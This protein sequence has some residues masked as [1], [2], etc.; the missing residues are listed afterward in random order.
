M[1][2][3]RSWVNV[4]IPH[5]RGGE[6]EA[7]PMRAIGEL[8]SRRA[9][10]GCPSRHHALQSGRAEARDPKGVRTQWIA[11]DVGTSR[12]FPGGPP[13]EL[14][15]S[16]PGSAR[17]LGARLDLELDALTP[18]EAVE[19]QGGVEGAAME[20]VFLRILGDDE[21]E[22]AIG[23]DLLD[24]TGGH[25]TSKRFPNRDGST[26]GPFEKGEIDHAEHRH[27]SAASTN[28]STARSAAD[29]PMTA[30]RIGRRTVLDADGP[31]SALRER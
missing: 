6:V 8:L 18:G 14:S 28:H 30:S 10:V 3:E 4:A 12:P 13:S 23:D 1:A 27:C 11:R 25:G 16:D 29:H 31:F 9:H 5:C 22:A 17:T 15:G 24:G 19:V 21:A 26:H 7:N 2:E 20:E